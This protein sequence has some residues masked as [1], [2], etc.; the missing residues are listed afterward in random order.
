MVSRATVRRCVAF[1]LF[2]IDMSKHT[3]SIQNRLEFI[4]G[5]R[6]YLMRPPSMGG[7]CVERRVNGIFQFELPPRE[8][9]E[10]NDLDAEETALA[11]ELKKEEECCF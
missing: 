7:K 4:R 2:D 9:Q 3:M 11:A 6:R 8:Q 1:P 10:L 5:Q